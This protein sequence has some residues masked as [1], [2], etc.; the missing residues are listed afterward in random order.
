MLKLTH[1]PATSPQS[2]TPIV[3]LH[4]WGSDSRI[5]QPLLPFLQQWGSVFTIDLDY[6]LGNIDTLCAAVA[7][8]INELP[9]SPLL[10]GWS[11]G[12]MVATRLA[13]QMPLAGL[14]TLAT[15]LRFVASPNWPDA[16]P[17]DIFQGF[18]QSFEASPAHALKRF[19]LLQSQGDVAAKQQVQWLN[20]LADPQADPSTLLA[21][22]KLLAEFDN[23]DLLAAIACPSLHLLGEKDALVPASIE[24]QLSAALRPG[25]TVYCMPGRGHLLH[26]PFSTSSAESSIEAY[27]ADFLAATAVK[28]EGHD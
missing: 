8:Q 5:W 19:S 22:L 9:Q 23:T 28:G 4:G 1:Y 25:Q 10:F 11:L 7:S 18:L 24:P 27:L 20:T 21:G 2:T 17:E 16:M 12:G 14:I 3:L 15:N 26:Y 6:Q 13:S